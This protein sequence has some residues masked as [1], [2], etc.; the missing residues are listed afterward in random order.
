VSDTE[1]S[2]LELGPRVALLLMR[3]DHCA[4]PGMMRWLLWQVRTP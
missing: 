1:L 3:S 4:L 2:I